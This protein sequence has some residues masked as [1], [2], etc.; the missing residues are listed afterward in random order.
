MSFFSN[1]V[2]KNTILNAHACIIPLVPS[3]IRYM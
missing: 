3:A 2:Q 1:T